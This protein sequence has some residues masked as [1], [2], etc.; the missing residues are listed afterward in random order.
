MELS[1]P[2]M[3]CMSKPFLIRKI[4]TAYSTVYFFYNMIHEQNELYYMVAIV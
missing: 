4:D 2:G 3:C 1:L